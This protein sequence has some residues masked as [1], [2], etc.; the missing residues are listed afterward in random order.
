[1][2]VRWPAGKHARKRAAPDPD[3]KQPSLAS[4]AQVVD[5]SKLSDRTARDAEDYLRR[6]RRMG[7]HVKHEVA[8]RLVSVIR[9]AGQS[10][11]AAFCSTAGHFCYGARGASQ[12]V[13]HRL[14]EC[15]ESTG[16]H[17]RAGMTAEEPA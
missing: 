16:S 2:Q 17:A 11:V 4:W 3:V 7:P 1:M 5:M 15:Q 13:R 10:T 14:T 8:L 9:Q 12:A 6:Y